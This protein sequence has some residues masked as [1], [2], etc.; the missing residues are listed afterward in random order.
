ML[1]IQADALLEFHP[2]ALIQDQCP[3]TDRNSNPV[4]LAM[5]TFDQFFCSPTP[6]ELRGKKRTHDVY[7]F[8]F[9]SSRQGN[10]SARKAKPAKVELYLYGCRDS[11]IGDFASRLSKITGC[12]VLLHGNCSTMHKNGGNGKAK[13]PWRAEEGW[14]SHSDGDKPSLGEKYIDPTTT[15]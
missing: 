10:R 14:D 5:N 4:V 7:D 11:T 9:R 12:K 8:G 6:I 3:K 2:G 13:D 1:E 15:W